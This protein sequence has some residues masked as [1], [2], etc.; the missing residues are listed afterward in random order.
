MIKKLN[1]QLY[2][3]RDQL[4]EDFS[5]TL[6]QLSDMGYDGVEFCGDYGGYAGDELKELLDY[7]GLTPVSCH[8]GM[9]ILEDDEQ[10]RYHTEILSKIGCRYIIMPSVGVE[11]DSDPAAFGRRLE[12]VA[13]KCAM[14]GFMF[15]FH[16]HGAEFESKDAD[17]VPYFDRMIEQTPLSLIEFD[18]YWLTKAGMNIEDYLRRYAGRINLL[19]LK[20]M[21]GDGSQSITA[22]ENGV[23][24]FEKVI[25]IAEKFGTEQVIYENDNGGEKALDA[26]KDSIDYFKTLK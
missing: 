9:Q 11:E 22:L 16:N 10:F 3:V 6:K 21:K 5:G 20:Q 17:G 12:A 8:L 4:R 24:D 2:S 23:V 13:Q 15:G 14:S 1:I 19:H 18:T 7:L 25:K 26:A